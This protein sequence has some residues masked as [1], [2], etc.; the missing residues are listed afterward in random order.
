MI[1]ELSKWI[2]LAIIIVAIIFIIKAGTKIINIIITALLLAFAWF[3]FFTEIGAVR[4][5]LALKGHPIIAYTTS[6][7]K[8]EKKSTETKA[9]YKVTNS[10][11]AKTKKIEYTSCDM[12]WIVKIP[13]IDID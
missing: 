9:Y 10:E 1:L 12:Y 6:L 2:V 3:S 4:L 13:N 11:L 8:D 7:E 5:A